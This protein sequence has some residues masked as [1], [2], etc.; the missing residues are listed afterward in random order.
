[1]TLSRKTKAFSDK[2]TLKTVLLLKLKTPKGLDCSRGFDIFFLIPFGSNLF[3]LEL[4]AAGPRASKDAQIYGI[5]IRILEGV[6][7]E[8]S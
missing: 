2:G 7:E 5:V 3:Q 8:T 4:N 6:L 1:M